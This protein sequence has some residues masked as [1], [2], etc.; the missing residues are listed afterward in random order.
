[1]QRL[2]RETHSDPDTGQFE[3]SCAP[4]CGPQQEITDAAFAVLGRYRQPPDIE[5]IDFRRVKDTS[6]RKS[7]LPAYESA[8]FAQLV[9]ERL[10]GFTI[11]ARRRVE[12][13]FVLLESTQQQSMQHRCV[14]T[15]R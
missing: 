3:C 6:H 10:H 7:A 4:F 11:G 8:T 15:V 14:A 9:F 12:L 1:M 13:A 2:E 5:V